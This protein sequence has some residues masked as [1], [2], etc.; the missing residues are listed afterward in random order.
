MKKIGELN[1][2]KGKPIDAFY[3]EQIDWNQTLLTAINNAKAI[4]SIACASKDEKIKERKL[5]ISENCK[6]IFNTLLYFNFEMWE[7][8]SFTNDHENTVK[9]FY[10]ENYVDINLLDKSFDYKND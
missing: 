5:E 8:I 7:G 9:V 4:M 6:D 3:G 1:W 10:D 2:C